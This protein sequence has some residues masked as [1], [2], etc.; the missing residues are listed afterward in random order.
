MMGIYIPVSRATH[1]PDRETLGTEL[2]K[3]CCRQVTDNKSRH[4]TRN[5]VLT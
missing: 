2:P 1:E 5:K 3:L 4:A